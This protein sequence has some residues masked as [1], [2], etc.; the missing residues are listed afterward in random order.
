MLR[1]SQQ[2]HGRERVRVFKPQLLAAAPPAAA[3]A[4]CLP[5]HSPLLRSHDPLKEKPSHFS[6]CIF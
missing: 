6:L 3:V 5:F 4:T 1:V 2:A